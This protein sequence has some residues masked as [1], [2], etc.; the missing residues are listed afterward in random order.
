M[1]NWNIAS[2]AELS[3]ALR[4]TADAGMT[5]RGDAEAHTWTVEVT[6]GG[7]PADLTGWTA[8]GY[9]IRADGRTVVVPG[10]ISGGTVAVVLA[11]A[12]YAVPGPVNGLLRVSRSDENITL[13]AMRMRVLSGGTGEIVDPEAIVPSVDGLVAQLASMRAA[14]NGAIDAAKQAQSAG[15]EALSAVNRL[16]GVAQAAVEKVIAPA[17]LVDCAFCIADASDRYALGISSNGRGT[18]PAGLDVGGPAAEGGGL[19]V[20][21]SEGAE[22]LTVA[23]G[24]TVCAASGFVVQDGQG[25]DVLTALADGVISMPGGL[26]V[27]GAQVRSMR[28][29]EIGFGVT[30]G[31]GRISELCS[32]ANGRVPDWVLAAWKA[33][34]E[35]LDPP[36]ITCWGDSLTAAGGWTERLQDLSGMAVH[37]GGAGGEGAVTIAAR[38]GADVMTLCG[39]TLP[40]GITPVTVATLA[41]GGIPTAR[42]RFAKPV[43]VLEHVNPVMLGSVEGTLCWT[44]ADIADASGAW[45]F[46][47]AK[48]GEAVAIDRPTALR[49]DF[50]RRYNAPHLMVLFLGQNGGYDNLD[51]LV[52]LHRRMIGHARAKHVLVLGLSS[53]T[54]AQ[55]A[56]YECRMAMEFGRYFLSLRRYL[57]API[58]GAD[59]GIVSCYGLDDAGLTATAADLAAIA[60][61]SVPPQMLRDGIHYTEATCLVVGNLIFRTCRDLNIFQ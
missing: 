16:K 52:W 39:V 60:E 43:R 23:S 7:A 11:G 26:D 36:Y 34:T 30:D 49:T 5:A 44:G 27:C 28:M 51:D 35:A 19:C 45:T 29:A 48:A 50:D 37:N 20:R 33:R 10:T 53:G 24:G 57:A 13:A 32:G 55:R 56:D 59:G 31:E 17:S 15:G 12:C 42:G 14:T 9:F 6:S 8:T 1:N 22:A 25:N 3:G 54:A 2:R 58:Y 21:D 41:D 40:A 46:T 47:R 18:L 61:G 4:Q 38:Q